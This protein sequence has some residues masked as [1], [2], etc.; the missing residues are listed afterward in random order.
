MGT[1]LVRVII[2]AVLQTPIFQ[3]FFPS[4]RD[5][6]HV[7]CA[8]AFHVPYPLPPPRFSRI[9]WQPLR[10]ATLSGKTLLYCQTMVPFSADLPGLD[11]YCDARNKRQT[12]S[13]VYS[14][15]CT[16]QSLSYVCIR[17]WCIVPDEALM[18]THFRREGGR[19]FR[20]RQYCHRALPF[21]SRSANSRSISVAVVP[22]V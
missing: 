2:S 8:P 21:T 15:M 1:P 5:P 10:L 9:S 3:V 17:V 18:Y 6:A 22:G 7:K 12:P 14:T 19:T 11:W 13:R 4:C 20:A 16:Y